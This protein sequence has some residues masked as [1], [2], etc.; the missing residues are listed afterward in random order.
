MKKFLIRLALCLGLLAFS[1]HVASAGWV[2][3]FDSSWNINALSIGAVICAGTG[4]FGVWMTPPDMLGNGW[5]NGEYASN[6]DVKSLLINGANIFAG[7]NGKGIYFSNDLG[8]SWATVNSGLNAGFSQEVYALAV[9]GSNIFAG[10]WSGVFLSTNNGTNWTATNSGLTNVYVH[11]LAVSGSNIFTGTEG[12]VFLSTN[13]GTSWTAVNSG[14]TTTG[15][16]IA[17]FVNSLAVRDSTIFAGT[18]D[19]GV[20]L[21]TNNGTSWTTVDSGLT[22][23]IVMS[24]ALCGSNIFAGTDGGGVFLSTNNGTSWTAVN[25]GLTN[26]RILS[27]GVDSNNIFA[28]TRG[29]GVW[30]RSLSEVGVLNNKLQRGKLDQVYLRVHSPGHTN[31][32]VAIEFSLTHSDQVV[33]NIYDLSGHEVATLINK[34]LASGAHSILWDT[35]H[36]A[37]GCYTVRMRAGSDT[38]VRSI[39]I[40][41]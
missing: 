34:N 35:R 14:L 6:I 11:A 17:E 38:Y 2:Q 19:D 15:G 29:S 16:A 26:L 23:T 5:N 4:G 36:L 7:T 9:I 31:P 33:V 8:Y 24:L 18:N 20:F 40:F 39:P 10:T 30:Y 32:I 25:S 28:G 3:T 1:T 27:L 12:G 41:R 21:S 22:N 37:T 13:N